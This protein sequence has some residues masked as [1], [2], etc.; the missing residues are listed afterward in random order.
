MQVGRDCLIEIATNIRIA[1]LLPTACLSALD[2]AANDA[3]EALLEVGRA[4]RY[5]G[6]NSLSLDQ[7]MNLP[8]N[9]RDLLLNSAAC[10]V[11][12]Y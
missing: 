6:I 1:D 8:W 9:G 3:V 12:C 11:G 2:F 5:F 10:S 4:D 7:R